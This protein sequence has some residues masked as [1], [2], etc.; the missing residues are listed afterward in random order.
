MKNLQ[1][2]DTHH[3]YSYVYHTYSDVLQK[4]YDRMYGV[5]KSNGHALASNAW[6]LDGGILLQDNVKTIAGAFFN[7][8]KSQSSILIHIIFV[9]EE[10]RRQGIYKR[11]HL[12][13]NQLGKESGR[14]NIYSYVHQSN[15]IMQKYI[16]EKIGYKPVMQL[17][18]R[19]IL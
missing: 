7:L 6:P 19:Q 17:M 16:V 5:I 10:Y 15:Y 12:L 9:E 8:T 4:E 11:M 1:I 3:G 18:T 2:L 14:T 13:I